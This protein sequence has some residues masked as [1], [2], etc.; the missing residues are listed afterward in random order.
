MQKV[1]K[2]QPELIIHCSG[3][4]GRTGTFLSAYQTYSKCHQ[5]LQKKLVPEKSEAVTIFGLVDAMRRQR[6]PWMVE[7]FQQFEMAY[8]II[9]HLLEDFVR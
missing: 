2:D 4:I 9:I 6:H 5:L 1:E 3:G 8:D 7:G